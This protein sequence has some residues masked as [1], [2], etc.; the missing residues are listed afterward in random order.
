MQFYN[1]L[2]FFNYK[3]NLRPII[4]NRK[5]VDEY[6]ER[7]T[8]HTIYITTTPKNLS[9]DEIKKRRNNRQLKLHI[10]LWIKSSISN[11]IFINYLNVLSKVLKYILLIKLLHLVY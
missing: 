8:S 4:L 3:I 7:E 10:F 2:V 6:I 9:T 5:R 1:F 11:L